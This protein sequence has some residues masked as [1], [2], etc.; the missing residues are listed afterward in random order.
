MQAVNKGSV[1]HI[2]NRLN[3]D[4]NMGNMQAMSAFRIDVYKFQFEEQ[5]EGD[6]LKDFTNLLRSLP[7]HELRSIL[8]IWVWLYQH[9]IA[10]KL[11]FSWNFHLPVWHNIVNRMKPGKFH[12]KMKSFAH[13]DLMAYVIDIS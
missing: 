7:M 6:V 4:V 13:E 5:L 8:K 3:W 11:V 10:F 2:L 9:E 12:R 1:A